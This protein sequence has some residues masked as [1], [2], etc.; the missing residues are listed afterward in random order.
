MGGGGGGG[1]QIPPFLLSQLSGEAGFLEGIARNM[2]QYLQSGTLPPGL[3]S[4]VQGATE[5]TRAGVTGQY[6][7]HGGLGSSGLAL[8]LGD[9]QRAKSS[10]IGRMGT[11]L[12]GLGLQA[13]GMAVNT[14]QGIM[15]TY[16]QNQQFN[17]SQNTAML[18]ELGK[19][20]GSILGL[21]PI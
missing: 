20:F 9:V 11:Q 15:D 7:A 16:V 2:T 19:A 14:W 4:Q 6:A 17:E 5:A 3:M 18:G 13:E 1:T 8:S 10:E 12:F 21:L